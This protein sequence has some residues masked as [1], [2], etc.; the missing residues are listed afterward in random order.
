MHHWACHC[1]MSLP[2]D[3]CCTVYFTMCIPPSTRQ[4]FVPYALLGNAIVSEPDLDARANRGEFGEEPFPYLINK[5]IT[6]RVMEVSGGWRQAC[7]RLR[8]QAHSQEAADRHAGGR[9]AWKSASRDDPL[10]AP[11]GQA[12]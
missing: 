7:A 12:S 11:S 10:S 4:G 2:P 5:T 8:M 6:V 3:L 1:T 9:T